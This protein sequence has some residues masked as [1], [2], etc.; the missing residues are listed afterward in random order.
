MELAAVIYLFGRNFNLG[1][2][3]DN[4]LTVDKLFCNALQLLLQRWLLRRE[5]EAEKSGRE[6]TMMTNHFQVLA[7]QA[8]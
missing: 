5:R 6:Q 4:Q 2:W 1:G 3:I 7:V 8:K